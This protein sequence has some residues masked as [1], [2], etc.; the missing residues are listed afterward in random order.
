M[1]TLIHLYVAEL[2]HCMNC[3]EVLQYADSILLYFLW[4]RYT[5]L[6]TFEGR[7]S[8]M[9]GLNANYEKKL[10]H[11]GSPSQI[12]H[13]NDFFSSWSDSCTFRLALKEKVSSQRFHLNDL[14]LSWT[15]SI[16]PSRCPLREKAGSQILHLKVYIP[17][18]THSICPGIQMSFLRKTCITIITLEW[19]LF[20]DITDSSFW[21]KKYV[22]VNTLICISF[23]L[24]ASWLRGC[25]GQR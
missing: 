5:S 2:E 24:Q 10:H 19:L 15:D 25:T 23:L 6:I 3:C 17:L 16:C 12:S 8:F 1:L 11:K 20:F 14:F 4:K 7:S 9:N 18:W 22:F 21:S 13:L